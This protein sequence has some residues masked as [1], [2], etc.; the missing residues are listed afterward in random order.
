MDPIDHDTALIIARES[1]NRHLMLTDA[2][3][4]ELE[5]RRLVWR[6]GVRITTPS[7]EQWQPS[8]QHINLGSANFSELLE[9]DA[10]GRI[11]Y[12]ANTDWAIYTLLDRAEK[13]FVAFE[14]CAELAAKLI[15]QGD[16][17]PA[18]IAAWAA[19][20]LRGEIEPPRRPPQHPADNM[21]R[22]RAIALTI[23]ELVGLGLNATR[24]AVS[25]S[26]SAC[27]VVSEVLRE[28]GNRRMSYSGVER[29]WKN[30][31]KTIRRPKQTLRRTS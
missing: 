5:R 18:R 26:D 28:S 24:N 10:A 30:Y 2:E 13:D 4:R 1:L 12:L 6:T 20:R 3:G 19:K 8:P 25:A 23:N 27:D 11:T 21:L 9:A 7:G 31:N 14:A 29:I 22:D 15:E 16:P 17:L